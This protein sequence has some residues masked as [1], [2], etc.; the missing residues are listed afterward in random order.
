MTT[1]SPPVDAVRIFEQPPPASP[2]PAPPRKLRASCDGCYLS[3]VKCTKERPT[4]HRC[5]NLSMICKYSPSQRMG[6]PRASRQASDLANTHHRK[7]STST[8]INTSIT[9]T[10]PE[11]EAA[12]VDPNNSFQ[13]WEGPT[14]QN[15]LG[16]SGFL[17]VTNDFD[18]GVNNMAWTDSMMVDGDS[19][20]SNYGGSINDSSRNSSI[21][22]TRNSFSKSATSLMDH[23][24]NSQDSSVTL[25]QWGD[26]NQTPYAP[27]SEDLSVI[28]DEFPSQSYF[29]PPSYDCFTESPPGC[30][31]SPP[32]VNYTPN[33]HHDCAGLTLSTMHNV[34]LAS[35]Q[36]CSRP[37][38][39]KVLTHNKAALHNAHTLLNCPC[40]REPH[41]IIMLSVIISKLLSWYQ[42]LGRIS[43]ADA[44]NVAPPS[45]LTVGEY[46]LEGD[47]AD[48]IRVQLVLNELRKIEKLVEGFSDRFCSGGEADAE[49]GNVYMALGG[50]LKRRLLETKDE[51]QR[52]SMGEREGN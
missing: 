24:L 15:Q 38:I 30:L 21:V 49:T 32:E 9:M 29:S 23:Q 34:H 2:K 50:F 47:D 3:K 25:K 41:M 18:G 19:G 37:T 22:F 8:S 20:G 12:F 17:P 39:D 48:R 31:P 6:K 42:A 11:P 44:Q 40:P 27:M 43:I 1:A 33:H 7:S 36:P 5:T 16:F 14:F 13:H 28:Q 51:L 4:C 46:R 35:N 26:M 52:I 45:S 10:R